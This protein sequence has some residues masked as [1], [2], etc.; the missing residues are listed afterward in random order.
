MLVKMLSS[1]DKEHLLKLAEL[2]AIADKP[3][4]WDGKRPNEVTSASNLNNVTIEKGMIESELL[5]DMQGDDRHHTLKN[6]LNFGN[7][8]SVEE[9]FLKKIKLLPVSNTDLPESRIQAATAVLRELLDGKQSELPSIP[10]L[11]L[12]QLMLVALS[13]GSISNIEW[14]LLKEVQ[15]HYN[16]KDFIFDDLLERAETMNTEVAKTISIILE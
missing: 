8:D 4:L 2:V 11:L 3:L 9:R 15:H 7:S 14:V 1:T 6:K 5:K 16:V 12:F 13:G 10:K